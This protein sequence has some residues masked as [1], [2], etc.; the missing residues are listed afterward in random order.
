MILAT[1]VAFQW[2][3]NA[4]TFMYRAFGA[5]VHVKKPQ[6]IKMPEFNFN[7]MFKM[8]LKH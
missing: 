8:K 5:H 7:L 3:R 4:K 2:G 6:V 1:T